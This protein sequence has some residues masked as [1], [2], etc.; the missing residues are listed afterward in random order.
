MVI[1]S[2]SRTAIQ[3]CVFH[4]PPYRAAEANNTAVVQK[5]IE[6]FHLNP[7]FFS[8]PETAE[9]VLH[10]A[11]CHKSDM[12]YYLARNYRNL[13]CIPDS[14]GNSPVFIACEVDDLPFVSWLFKEALEEK[15]EENSRKDS[16]LETRT[17]PYIM[18][19]KSPFALTTRTFAFTLARNFSMPFKNTTLLSS[20]LA[21]E[22]SFSLQNGRGFTFLPAGDDK[23]YESVESQ[24]NASSVALAPEEELDDD[25]I[26]EASH[27]STNT[28][29]ASEVS[30]TSTIISDVDESIII[31]S[32]P[33]SSLPI[34]F[35]PEMKLFRK[36]VDGVSILHV[37]A[38]Q[39]HWKLLNTV[40]KV[41][42]KVQ[43]NLEPIDLEVLTQRE[44]FTLRTPIEEAMML[45]NLDCVESLI[46]FAGRV[47]LMKNLFMDEDLIKVAVL[48]DSEP[49]K[50]MTAVKMLISFG[51]YLGLA[52]SI[53]LADLKEMHD[54]VRILLFYQ[55]QVVNTLEFATVHQNHSVGLKTGHIKWEG[56]NLRF[57]DGEWLQDAYSAVD[58]VST[59][60]NN[61][62]YPVQDS[63]RY[64]QQF[65]QKLGEKCL[66][67]FDD[68]IPSLAFPH[69]SLVPI[70]DM[71]L[72]EN[73][74]TSVPK[75][76]FKMSHL[77]LLNL[78]HNDLTQLPL[79][80]TSHEVVYCCPKLRKLDLDWNSL[81]TLPE[82][83]CRGLGKSLEELSLVQ[84]QLSEL[85]PGLWVMRKLKKLVLSNNKLN[86]L[87][88]FSSRRYFLDTELT[89]K[90]VTLFEA[91]PSGR[92]KAT[93]GGDQ[94]MLQ[95]VE[96]YLLQ[97][98][99]F[100]KTV[101]VMQERNT[102]CINL[103]QAVIDI[104]WRRYQQ[105]DNLPTIPN[106]AQ[107]SCVD[108]CCDLTDVDVDSFDTQSSTSGLQEL[109]LV[110]N[111]FQELPWD[112]ACIAPKLR[113]LYFAENRMTDLDIVHSIPPSI[114]S[115]LQKTILRVGEL[116]IAL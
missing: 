28:L 14:K 104:H 8:H 93:S 76:L 89:R 10:F 82:E 88:A 16:I 20:S 85:P 81:K 65:F 19:P 2:V 84:N 68:S 59:L 79:P 107:T 27:C 112:L 64:S 25:C 55:T 116:Y 24:S 108:V 111:R 67:Y 7:L 56:F 31:G 94:E 21:M 11:C 35:I 62:E 71:N 22:P 34:D 43:H 5:L 97:L 37:L 44:G 73:H 53:A 9:N 109:N 58:S 12:R 32:H 99:S 102:E 49:T 17:L 69:Y 60:F 6:R 46:K 51:F 78:S 66:D 87:H 30:R 74:L 63:F 61:P 42:E 96:K 86:H 48:L 41:A 3:S 83:L 47:N 113:R 45:G 72:S 103:A 40:L 15:G 114:S 91:T 75:E 77:R 23:G 105:S 101:M 39:G 29:E 98:L 26:F 70:V 52:K 13:L 106:S 115:L 1:L 18:K 95:K 38:C 36:N 92:F 50:N 90:V 33:D 4:L 80:E 110:H 100:L 54:I 57:V